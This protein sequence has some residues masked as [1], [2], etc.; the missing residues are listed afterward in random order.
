[1]PTPV[2]HFV[3]G[4]AL[5]QGARPPRGAWLRTAVVF[6]L[7]ASLQDLDFILLAFGI[8]LDH[9]LGHRGLTHSL[10]FAV[11]LG[12][13]GAMALGAHRRQRRTFVVTAAAGFLAAASHGLLDMVTRGGSGVALLMPFLSERWSF[14]FQPINV[15]LLRS[16]DF[17]P[18]V[19]E[20]FK[21]EFLWIWIPL[22]LVGVG[23][24]LV[25]ATGP[26][27]QWH[28]RRRT[29]RVHPGNV[30]RPAGRAAP[31]TPSG[32]VSTRLRVPVI[33][34]QKLTAGMD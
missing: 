30:V 28:K 18:A 20:V 5:S 23:R 8:P 4:A 1:M 16:G 33:L 10:A 6:G 29:P 32:P 26:L 14:P 34:R 17:V 19:F 13:L 11:L 12:I 21:S 31:P 3:V 7:L 2:T 9:P 27:G 15:S 22:A 24:W 25:S